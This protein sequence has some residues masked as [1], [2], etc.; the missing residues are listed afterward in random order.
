V[1]VT[2]ARTGRQVVGCA[3]RK[4]WRAAR[5]GAAAG[6]SADAAIQS[7]WQ[8]WL[9]YLGGHKGVSLGCRQGKQGSSPQRP[10][11]STAA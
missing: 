6:W 5:M 8:G 7:F 1:W 10:G 2:A 3:G 9:A 11:V 4:G